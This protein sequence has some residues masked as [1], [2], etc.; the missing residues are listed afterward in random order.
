[1]RQNKL[2][3][4]VTV[5]SLSA[6]MAF[7]SVLSAVPM[8]VWAEENLETTFAEP[9]WSVDFNNGYGDLQSDPL[10]ETPNPET[11]PA[12]PELVTESYNGQEFTAL[13][14]NKSAGDE[15]WTTDYYGASIF[16]GYTYNSAIALTNPFSNLGENY[17]R[18]DWYTERLDIIE[19][20]HKVKIYGKYQPAWENGATINYWVKVPVA[21]ET[22]FMDR[23]VGINSSVFTWELEDYQ[24]QADDYA[25]YLSGD[26]SEGIGYGSLP[27]INQDTGEYDLGISTVRFAKTH[28]AMQIDSDGSIYWVNDDSF[29]I[30]LN[31][32][33]PESFASRA[34][35][36][37]GDCFFMNSWQESQEGQSAES[38]LYLA[39]SPY[40]QPGEWHMVTVTLMN[41][42]IEFY[43][44]G[45]M[46]DVDQSYSSRGGVALDMGE[47]FKRFNKGTG[48]RYGYGSEKAMGNLR[49]GNY[50][51]RLFLDWLT[52]PRTTFTI[53][54]VT[55]KNAQANM[56]N[57]STKTDEISIAKIDMY[58]V[59]VGEEQIAAMY[60]E[61]I[62]PQEF[63]YGDTDEDGQ[64]TASD[65]LLVLKHVVKLDILEGIPLKA[66]DVNT[67]ESIA[68]E[69]ALNILKYV[70]KLIDALPVATAE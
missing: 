67:D 24:F 50:V 10:F 9:F 60:E 29:G 68:A 13:K 4:I 18:E 36:Q 53:G 7:T 46:V 56:Y 64:V 27:Q 45:E 3:R 23:V 48:M 30:N 26:L 41:D 2:F 25:K 69:D 55:V 6:T 61:G 8:W 49:Y 43:L 15:V 39:D 35:M 63:L 28:G 47:S 44:D 42:W 21:E 38:A 14:L 59:L 16:A 58:S 54:G 52:S 32:N 34:G 51:C 20:D 12:A 33:V 17:F 37:N 5:F 70:V 1:M 31:G 19:S 11:N 62:H 57:V 40:S 22:D 65:A 66:A